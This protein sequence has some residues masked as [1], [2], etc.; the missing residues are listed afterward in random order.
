MFTIKHINSEGT[1]VLV[2]CGRFVRE[3]R[4]DGF[5]QYT[6]RHQEPSDFADY[7]ASWCGDE[8]GT[9]I[10]SDRLYVMNR[11]GS[12]VAVHCFNKPD[13]SEAP[14]AQADPELVAAAR[15]KEAA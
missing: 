4:S 12:T 5:I 1:E 11:F 9:G 13:F 2:E 14:L 10:K 3:R 8:G 15:P 7:V 6:A